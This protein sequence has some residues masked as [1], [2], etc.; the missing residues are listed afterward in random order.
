MID[1]YNSLLPKLLCFGGFFPLL[2]WSTHNYTDYIS[3]IL[4]D[5]LS[6]QDPETLCSDLPR[7][8][9]SE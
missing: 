7:I 4:G 8:L 5:E 9:E 6:K 3:C 1:L 2:V